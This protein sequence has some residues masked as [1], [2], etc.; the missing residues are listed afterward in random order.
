MQEQL[1]IRLEELRKEFET[2]QVELEKVE[3]QRSYLRDTLLRIEG[4]IQVL[5]E[6]LPEDSPHRGNGTVADKAQPSNPQG[7]QLLSSK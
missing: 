7:G 3:R 5:Q 4:A 1:Q 2:G 6:L